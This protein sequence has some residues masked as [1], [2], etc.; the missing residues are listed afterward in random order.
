M[1]H[2][3]PGY[4][5]CRHE[6]EDYCPGSACE[7]CAGAGFFV[8]EAYG[9]EAFELADAHGLILADGSVEEAAQ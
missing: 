6:C 7:V 8:E 4:F 5:S 2:Y 9:A 1:A 3:E